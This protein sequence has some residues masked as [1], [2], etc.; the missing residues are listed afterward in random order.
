MYLKILFESLRNLLKSNPSIRNLG[1]FY[2]SYRFGDLGWKRIINN[3][4]SVWFNYINKT[5]TKKVLVATSF[6]GELTMPILESL[7]SASLSIRNADVQILLCDGLSA[8][9]LCDT[10]RFKSTNSFIQNG[11][12][13]FGCKNCF[14]TGNR[15]Y[16]GWP[17][18]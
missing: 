14:S 8:C 3:N 9:Q 4:P 18:F 13:K 15:I 6:G 5:K 2:R 12:S 11:P 1:R 7:I 17:W 16:R 10:T